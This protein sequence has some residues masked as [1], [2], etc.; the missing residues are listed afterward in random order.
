[1]QAQ[2]CTYSVTGR[3]RERRVVQ[4]GN[5]PH[6][7]RADLCFEAHAILRR[8]PELLLLARE[9]ALSF[10]SAPSAALV[11]EGRNTVPGR[12]S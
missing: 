9:A 2:S 11:G 7:R 5:V 12:A 10:A 1:L 8:L 4:Q 3:V 6:K